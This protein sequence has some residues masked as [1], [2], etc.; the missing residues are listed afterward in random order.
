MLETYKAILHGDTLEWI[1]E[2]PDS[3][4]FAGVEVYVTLLEVQA[5]RLKPDGAAMAAALKAISDSGISSFGDAL[6]WQREVRQDR[7][8]PGREND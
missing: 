7:K 6:D 5:K 4:D 1:G 3:S 2:K 8:L